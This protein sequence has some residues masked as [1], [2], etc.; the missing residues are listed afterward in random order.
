MVRRLVGEVAAVGGSS[1]G[2]GCAEPIER[3]C[4]EIDVSG[5]WE[6]GAM[7]WMSGRGW[8]WVNALMV[9]LK[10]APAAELFWWSWWSKRALVLQVYT[11]EPSTPLLQPHVLHVVTFTLNSAFTC[12]YLLDEASF[13]LPIDP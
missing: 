3:V 9:A 12:G 13:R 7:L 8:W 2:G 5:E 6:G 4:E 11:C 1:M 10:F